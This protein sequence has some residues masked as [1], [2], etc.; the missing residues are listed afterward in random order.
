MVIMD[1]CWS[2]MMDMAAAT[3]W[4]MMSSSEIVWFCESIM[5]DI[6]TLA[7]WCCVTVYWKRVMFCEIM[8]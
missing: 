2:F 7:Y 4:P 8:L 6:F 1:D 3:D 5:A